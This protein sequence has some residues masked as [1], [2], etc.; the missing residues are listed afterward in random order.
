MVEN[1]Q[2]K[3]QSTVLETEK[4]ELEMKFA[5]SDETVHIPMAKE[6]DE[7]LGCTVRSAVPIVS[8]QQKHTSV[9]QVAFQSWLVLR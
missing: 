7:E 8:L 6:R 5:T 4:K 3:T 2:L 1:S 9:T